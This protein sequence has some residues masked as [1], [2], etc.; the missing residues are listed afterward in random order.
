MDDKTL[1]DRPFVVKRPRFDESGHCCPVCGALLRLQHQPRRGGAKRYVC[2][3]DESEVYR[4][5]DTGH[6]KR[7]LDA[8]HPP[9]LKVYCEWDFSQ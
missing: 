1:I 6:L 2:P 7:D 3:V 5:P 9:G 4:D 8:K